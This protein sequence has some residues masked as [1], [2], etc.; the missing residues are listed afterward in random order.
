MVYKAQ[1]SHLYGWFGGIPI[2]GNHYNNIY[3]YIYIHTDT[4]FWVHGNIS[5]FGIHHPTLGASSGWTAI[6][7]S[8]IGCFTSSYITVAIVSVENDGIDFDGIEIVEK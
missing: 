6:L 8:N 5:A 1:K 4:C 7:S 3:I 2:S